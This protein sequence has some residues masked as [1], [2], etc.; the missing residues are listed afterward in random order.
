MVSHELKTPLTTLKAYVQML[1]GWAKKQKDAFTMGTLF[2]VERQVKKMSTMI[3]G[4]LN[5][6]QIDSGKIV[7]NK[8]AFNLNEL[9]QDTIEETTLINPEHTITFLP[10][11]DIDIIADRE[12]IEQVI[13][14]L[15]ANAVKYSPDSKEIR[16]CCAMKDQFVHIGVIDKGMG[17]K[18]KDINLLFKR[19]YRVKGKKMASIPGFGIGLYLCA[20]I[21][22]RHKGRI[23]VESELGKGSVF[24]FSLPGKK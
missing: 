11:E 23:W 13:I 9:I 16:V 6:S 18:Q 2:K 4:F 8:Q 14:N 15:L 12:K 19:Y 24:W 3:S 7:L 17:I 10:C 5:L 1:H 21:V 22:K 20:E